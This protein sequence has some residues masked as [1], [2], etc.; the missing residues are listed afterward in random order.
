MTGSSEQTSTRRSGGAGVDDGR[1]PTE[2][3]RA[4]MATERQKIKTKRLS[5]Q[6][7]RG[8]QQIADQTWQQCTGPTLN[9]WSR[10]VSLVRL[11]NVFER[12]LAS[13]PVQ[14]WLLIK[15]VSQSDAFSVLPVNHHSCFVCIFGPK[16]DDAY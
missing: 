15:A 1:N 16:V 3:M 6:W 2:W 7:M 13:A 12:L 10:V 4:Q 8:G 14:S 11:A 5:G 9:T